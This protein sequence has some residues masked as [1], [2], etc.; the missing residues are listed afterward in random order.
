MRIDS[1]STKRSRSFYTFSEN[2]SS[3]RENGIGAPSWATPDGKL[4]PLQAQIDLAL[5]PNLGLRDAVIRIDIDGL[6]SAGYE[7]PEVTH[8]G[9]EY[10]MPGGGYEM[11]FPY[12]VPPEFLKVQSP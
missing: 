7:I 9:R 6:R 4:S 5:S 3:I 1:N 8:V 2:L 10:N 11:Q 12:P